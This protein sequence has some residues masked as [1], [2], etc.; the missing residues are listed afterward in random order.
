MFNIAQTG[1]E[2]LHNLT[3]LDADYVYSRYRHIPQN[4]NFAI[5]ALIAKS[6]LDSHNVAYPVSSE[7][8]IKLTEDIAED[9]KQFTIHVECIK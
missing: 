2:T 9:A 4:I 7:Q 8:S 6:F 3:S 1:S 5:K